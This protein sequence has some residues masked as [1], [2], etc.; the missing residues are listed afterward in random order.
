[1]PRRRNAITVEAASVKNLLAA[2]KFY[3]T[4]LVEALRG[5]LGQNLEEFAATMRKRSS[6]GPL[7]KRSG[8][9]KGSWVTSVNT[10]GGRLAGVSGVIGSRAFYSKIH[11][12]GETVKPKD[13]RGWIY[14]PTIYNLKNNGRARKTPRQIR[15]EGGRFLRI[16]A[17]KLEEP[18]AELILQRMDFVSADLLL[19]AAN[20]PAFTLVKTATYAARLGFYEEGAKIDPK[21]TG[22]LGDRI[23]DFW[24]RAA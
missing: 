24:R 20:F 6:S 23:T 2:T 17:Y 13:P 3:P 16:R 21:L 18:N 10:G 7:F 15:E 9:L 8:R 14:I 12:F 1:M 22:A 5:E 19:D 11:E 4:F